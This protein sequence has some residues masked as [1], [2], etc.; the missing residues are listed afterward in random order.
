MGMGPKALGL[1]MGGE[2]REK[3]PCHIPCPDRW[4]KKTPPFLV[5][6]TLSAMSCTKAGMHEQRAPPALHNEY[7]A[8]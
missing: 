5:I 8:Y 3:A 6:N 1:H 2:C 7:L 4:H